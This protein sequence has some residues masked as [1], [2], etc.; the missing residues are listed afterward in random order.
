MFNCPEISSLNSETSDE[1]DGDSSEDDD[2]DCYDDV[3][4]EACN[5]PVFLKPGTRKGKRR[6]IRKP[7]DLD[8]FYDCWGK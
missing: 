1:P 4:Y 3:Q 8:K 5:F 2:E 7:Q 6:W